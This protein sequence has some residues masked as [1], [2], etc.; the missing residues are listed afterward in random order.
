[1]K[2]KKIDTGSKE[3]AESVIDTVREPLIVLDNDLMVIAASRSFY[4]VFR[5]KPKQTLGQHIYDLGNKQ[6]DIPKLRELLETILPD[7]TSFDNYEVEHNFS[8]IGQRV[9]LL[10]ARRVERAWGKERIILLAIEDVTE[11]KRLEDLLNESEERY[12]RLFET[13]SDGIV[14]LEKNA[15]HITHANPA[16][17]EMLGYSAEESLGK[18]LQD[19]GVPIDMTDFPALMEILRG[20]GILNYQDVPVKTK[21]GKN[22]CTDI[23][24][25]DR[26]SLAQ[27]NIRDISERKRAEEELRAAHWS[28]VQKLTAAAE[29]RDPETGAHI[30]KIGL[31]TKKMAEAMQMPLDSIETITFASSLHDIGKIGIPDNILLKPGP[32]NPAEFKIMKT[33]S[34][35]GENILGDSS[36]PGIQMASSIALNHHERWDGSGYPRGLKGEE[37]PLESRIVMLVDQYDALR[38]QRP[39]KPAFDHQKTCAIITEGDGNTM[40]EHFDPAILN[41]FKDTA[42]VFAE[43]FDQLP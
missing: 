34:E 41:A 38:S 3:F 4:E 21:R 12:R 18:T 36:Y 17:V 7:K 32:L 13:A 16:V 8:D 42:P 30:A 20:S 28:L 14:L 35:I 15:G 40:P 2:N 11:R 33:H 31:Y 27:C 26:A 22:I 9:M 10:N 23:Y 29:F 1:M 24:L 43:I 39:Y 25:V 19:L 6:W 37:T 5:V